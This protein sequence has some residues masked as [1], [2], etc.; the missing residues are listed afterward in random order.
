MPDTHVPEAALP[1]LDPLA[2]IHLDSIKGDVRDWLLDRLKHDHSALPWNLRGEAEQTRTIDQA[3]A[4][5]EELVKRVVE[6]VMSE[7]RPAIVATLK[8]TKRKGEVIAGE[9]QFPASEELR[10]AFLD[11]TSKEVLVVMAPTDLPFRDRGKPKA[12][13]DQ[14]G[15]FG[16]EDGDAAGEEGGGNPPDPDDNGPVFDKTPSGRKG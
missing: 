12:S 2:Q 16:D 14:A 6:L 5:A 4:K 3:D 11:A 1:S 9:V 10:H 13:P 7:G 15:L 8:Q